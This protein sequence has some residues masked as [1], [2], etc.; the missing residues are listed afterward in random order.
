M[1]IRDSCYTVQDFEEVV[2]AMAEGRINIEKAKHMITGHEKIEDGFEKGIMDL[3]NN[4]ETN[5]KILLTPNNF[6]ELA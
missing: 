4:K 5:I 3:I 2:E 1:C 6:N